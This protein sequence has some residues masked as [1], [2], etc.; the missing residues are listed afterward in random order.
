MRTLYLL[1]LSA[2]L[3]PGLAAQQD[4]NEFT[5]RRALAA[6]K[7]IEIIG[8]NGAIFAE[9]T[10]GREVEVHATKRAR[11]SDL[12]S[13]TFQVIEHANG[14]TIC[15]MYPSDGRRENECLEG[16]KGR[17]N[18]RDNDVE[19]EWTV[20]VPAGVELAARTVNGRVEAQGLT[21]PAE[22]RTVNGSIMIET[23][24]WADASTVNGSITARMGRADW[25]GSMDFNTVNGGITLYLPS[26]ASFEVR[27]S[28][29]NGGMS[30]D[31][32]LT[33][34]G[35]WGPHRM[36]GTVGSGG[37]QLGL[38]TVNGSLDLRKN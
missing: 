11:R 33:I 2:L 32:P 20:R 22:A 25:T 18:T 21:A 13:V 35:R 8:V 5:W 37:R 29:V 24:S 12:G 19:V 28:N 10:S 27:A 31:F 17:M 14:V 4:R 3:A 36:T 38:S 9:G 7:S 16:G 26:S 15:A 1:S 34:Q 23:T 6:G 30:T